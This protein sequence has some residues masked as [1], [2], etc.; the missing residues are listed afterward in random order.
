MKAIVVYY[1]LD[2]NTKFVAEKIAARLNADTLELKPVKPYPTGKISKFFWCGKSASFREKPQLEDYAFRAEDYSAVIVGTPLWA[3]TIAPPL[4]TFLG[5]NDISK[6]RIAAFICCSGG[7]AEKA[8]GT[9]REEAKQD[10]LAAELK[11]VN[12]RKNGGD[13]DGRVE[14]FCKKIAD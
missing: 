2:G 10:V 4:R 7:S 11:L 8:F 13:I 3:G 12:A 1:S 9:I 14:E 6:K 5:D